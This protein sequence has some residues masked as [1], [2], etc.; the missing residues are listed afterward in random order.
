[1]THAPPARDTA[2]PPSD[3]ARFLRTVLR[4]D[5]VSTAVTGVVLL[6]AAG[7]LGSV[8][9]MPVAFSTV[10]GT[11]LA[12]GAV[13]LLWISRRRFLPPPLV[14]AV[15]AVNA[16]SAVGCAA[17]ALCGVLALTGFGVA[18]LLIGALVVTAYAALEWAGLRRTAAA[19]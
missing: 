7:P 11:F 8:T 3:P 18:F 4:V 19:R 16:V 6:V 10:F 2:P 12:C 15:V 17:V 5:G 9:G 1:M 13:A 14:R